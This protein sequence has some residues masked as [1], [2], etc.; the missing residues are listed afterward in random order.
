MTHHAPTAESLQRKHESRWERGK[1]FGPLALRT[2]RAIRW[3]RRAEQERDAGDHDVAFILYWIA[4]NAAYARDVSAESPERERQEPG[5]KEPTERREFA[6]FFGR[7]LRSD[8]DSKIFDA[9]WAKYSGPVRVLLSSEY[10]FGPFWDHANGKPGNAKWKDWFAGAN[11][12]VFRSLGEQ[13]TKPVLTTLFE[14][15]YTLRNQLV[16]GGSTWNSTLNRDTVTTGARIMEF[17]VPVFV[18][19]MLDNPDEDW[20]PP[21]YRLFPALRAEKRRG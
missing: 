9:I 11:R 5:G 2:Y 14:R 7:L 3:L 10:L 15:L 8:Q 20:G 13:R 4:F 17:L 12:R 18:E 1:A 6:K 19:I 21:Y 16:H